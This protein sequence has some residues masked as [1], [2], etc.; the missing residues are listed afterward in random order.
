MSN[1]PHPITMVGYVFGAAM[2]LLALA[3][4]VLCSVFLANIVFRDIATFLKICGVWQ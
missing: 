2:F 3:G 4:I 1:L